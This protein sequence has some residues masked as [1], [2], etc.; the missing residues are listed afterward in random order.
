MIFASPTGGRTEVS[1]G[2]GKSIFE[3]RPGHMQEQRPDVDAELPNTDSKIESTFESCGQKKS[4]VISYG[5][6]SGQEQ[7]IRFK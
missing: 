2:C 5:E 1:V 6:A 3:N 4:P 7:I